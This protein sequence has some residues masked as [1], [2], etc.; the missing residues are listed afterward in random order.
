MSNLEGIQY[1]GQRNLETIVSNSVIDFIRHGL[2]ELGAYYNVSN[3]VLRPVRKP[4]ATGTGFS[5]FVGIKH[6]WVFSTGFIPKSTGIALPTIPSGILYNNTF[7]STGVAISGNTWHIDFSQGKVI[8]ANDCPSGTSVKT[9][10]CARYVG[11]YPR[12]SNEYTRLVYN[13]SNPSGTTKLSAEQ[14]AY[15]PCI[16][17]ALNGYNTKRGVGLGSRAKVA[18]CRF[19]FDILSTDD[20]SRSSLQDI[21]CFM[22]TKTIPILDYSRVVKPL[23]VSGVVVGT[24]TWLNWSTGYVLGQGRF[25]E[26]ASVQIS[27]KPDLPYKASRVTNNLEL[28]VFPI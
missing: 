24:Q 10:Y 23:N 9:S 5:E 22:E 21:C 27:D 11:V 16:F 20:F 19:V 25:G 4:L 13:W 6:D 18:D 28:D 3:G 2:L 15:L 26:D 8:F 14:E 1:F 17:V 7:V 12:R